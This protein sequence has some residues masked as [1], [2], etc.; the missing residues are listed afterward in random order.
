MLPR[1]LGGAQAP[2]KDLSQENPLFHFLSVLVDEA[3]GWMIA[4]P[5]LG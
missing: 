3:L 4:P 2:P 1:I 5:R